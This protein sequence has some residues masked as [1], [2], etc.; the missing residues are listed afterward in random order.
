MNTD[1]YAEALDWL[2]LQTRAGRERSP[3]RMA[4]LMND[5]GLLSPARIVHVVGTNGKGTVSAMIEAGLTYS[6]LRTGLFIS[7]HVEDYRE[8]IS[9]SGERI[10]AGEVSRFVQ[11]LQHKPVDA[12]FFELSLLLAL[13]HFQA[14]QV[15]T[16]VLEAGVGARNDATL[17]LGN[18]VLTVISSISLDHTTTLGDTLALIAEDKSAAIRPRVP[19]V[20]A[21]SGEVLEVIAR[22]ALEMDSPLH[23]PTTHPELF[24]VP[25]SS[26]SPGTRG[27]NQALAAA[28]LRL[29]GVGTDGVLQAGTG[30]PPLPGRGEWFNVSGRQVL[31]DGAHD[32]SAA[33]ELV[34]P[35]A[36]GYTLLYAG[37]GRKQRQ[38]TLSVLAG[39][40]RAVF[41]TEL[42]QDGTAEW[43]GASIVSDNRAALEA[44]L[45]ATEAG[46]TLLISGSL[47]LAG[48]LR[49]SIL[50]LA[51]A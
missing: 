29:L 3:E 5:Y 7:P 23:H 10:S 47:Y 20:T 46:G 36:A 16:L 19:V 22:T 49:P 51:Q 17:A 9:V 38:E 41:L 42:G 8:R 50:E 1:R 48:S 31:L 26:A 6:G 21:E 34:R 18:T 2:F 15:E 28:S 25:A 44:A 37:L 43:T 13:R 39:K 27:R 32:P 45:A 35:L 4:Q 30:R 33:A 14:R 11:Q 12:A 40:A 24:E